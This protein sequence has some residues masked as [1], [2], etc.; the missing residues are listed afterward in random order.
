[1]Q[2]NISSENPSNPF[3]THV[4]GLVP[5]FLLALSLVIWFSFQMVQTIKTRD[6]LINAINNQE[7]QIQA[8]NKIKATLSAVATGTKQLANQG[9]S[10][11]AQIVNA[12]AQRGINIADPNASQQLGK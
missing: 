7:P 4:T 1:M 3:E 10:N 2:N 6:G 9:N 12:L 5:I 8:A 11:A